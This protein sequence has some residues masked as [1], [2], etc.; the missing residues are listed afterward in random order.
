M[1][2]PSTQVLLMQARKEI[3]LLREQLLMSKGFTIQQCLD[4]A[5]IALH[6]EFGFGP[7]YNSR[8]A[9]AFRLAF[10]EYAERCISDSVEDAEIV[11][12]KEL[13]DR[14]LRA[15]CGPDILPFDERYAMD[16]L[17]FRDRREEWKNG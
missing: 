3:Q 2:K 10:V 15:A 17:Y 13:V 1:P 6:D 4:M 5:Q 11:Y 16:Q 7:A 9:N 14:E 12:T 8:F